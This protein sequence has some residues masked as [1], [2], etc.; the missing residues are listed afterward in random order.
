MDIEAIVKKLMGA[1][2]GLNTYAEADMRAA[3]TE[4][5]AEY[6][7]ERKATEFELSVAKERIKQL[8]AERVPEVIRKAISIAAA[9]CDAV[10]G[11]QHEVAT[12]DWR[13]HIGRLV[14]ERTDG[15]SGYDI[16]REAELII[17]SG[18]FKGDL[19]GWKLVPV[20]P[21][22]DMLSAYDHCDALGC[23]HAETFWS[24]ML[25]AAPK[26]KEGE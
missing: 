4:L 17:A 6:D 23:E 19:D 5:A 18:N 2:Y 7:E 25:A 8:E 16:V 20:E 13:Q 26:H 1:Y 22:P 11:H 15:R 9:I 21:T 24:A 12:D 3:L 10:P 14:N